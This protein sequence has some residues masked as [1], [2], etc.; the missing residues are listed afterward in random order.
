MSP[1][2]SDQ[3]YSHTYSAVYESI[4]DTDEEVC[5]KEEEVLHQ[6]RDIMPAISEQPDS[7]KS[8]APHHISQPLFNTVQKRLGARTEPRE[9]QKFAETKFN[10]EEHSG[11]FPAPRLPN[12][13]ELENNCALSPPYENI[14]HGYR[15]LNCVNSLSNSYSKQPVIGSIQHPLAQPP[16]EFPMLGDT[17]LHSFVLSQ[18]KHNAIPNASE[19]YKPKTNA[20]LTTASKPEEA[21]KNLL[22]KSSNV[23]PEYGKE[24]LNKAQIPS[25]DG[26]LSSCSNIQN[27]KSR[28][29]TRHCQ[30]GIQIAKTYNSHVCTT[31]S[32]FFPNIPSHYF[33]PTCQQ[34]NTRHFASMQG[35]SPK[36]QE[37]KG[38]Q[39]MVTG[40]IA[41]D[42][43]N[44]A[45]NHS[46]KLGIKSN[47][48]D[49]KHNDKK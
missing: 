4:D 21:S 3:Y 14:N 22:L 31:A 41:P 10:G 8:C 28:Q 11:T 35:V 38:T 48:L 19:F 1:S 9:G 34:N 12:Y 7:N 17:P 36:P 27:E 32:T 37:L 20:E 33:C 45:S 39:T 42:L 15:Q 47:C 6:P 43:L 46:R 18:A 49:N 2:H 29:L 13:F 25:Q 24:H 30:H 5:P 44:E 40:F 23:L 26:L 16:C